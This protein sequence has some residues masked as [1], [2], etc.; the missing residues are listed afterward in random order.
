MSIVSDILLSYAPA[1]RKQTPSG[2]ISFDAPCC[3]YNGET[4]DKKQRGG[5]I[6]EGDTVSYHCFNCGY[7]T[8]WQPGRHIT[9]KMRKLLEWFNVPDDVINKL[10]L[11]VLRL[12]EGVEAQEHLVEMPVF[13]TVQLPED[14]VRLVDIP[15]YNEN[16]KSF[17]YFLQVLEF[18]T[19]RNL[20]LDDTDYYWSPSLGY[21]DRLIIPFYYEKRIVGWTARAIT[22]DKQPKYLTDSQP[23]F[24]YGLDEQRPQK[25]FCIVC[26]GPIDA[27][28][29]EG[30]ALTGSEI[31]E[32]QVMLLNKLHKE[33]IVVPDRDSKGKKLVEQALD[34]GWSISMPEW[35][36]D[37]NDIG[38]CVQR[39]GRLY[40]LYSIV[41]AAESS[42][43]KIKLRMKKWFT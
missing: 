25:I 6:Q 12:N 1:K 17:K 18:M 24:V 3:V 11:D 32:Q 35:A 43:L 26:E 27:I 7:K 41:S 15:D 40:T 29:I 34:L 20:N 28:H 14:A 4:A 9:F 19:K 31:S 38:D 16:N 30:C 33:I 5:V 13:A 21:R 39:H 37:I 22:P 8:G 36:A 42:P 2:W 10:A 23:G